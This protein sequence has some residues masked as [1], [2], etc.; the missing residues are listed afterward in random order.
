MEYDVIPILIEHDVPH[1][2][3]ID[4]DRHIHREW[5]ET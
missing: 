3:D 1:H 4:D 5:A 2:D